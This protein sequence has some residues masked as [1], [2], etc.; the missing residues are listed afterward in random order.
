MGELISFREL[1]ED[2]VEAEEDP[3]K[4]NSRNVEDVVEYRQ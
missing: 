4:V 2:R 1:A 3:K